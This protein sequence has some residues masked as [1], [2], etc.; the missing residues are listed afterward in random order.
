MRR[1][2]RKPD[3]P[4]VETLVE[5]CGMEKKSDTELLQLLIKCFYEDNK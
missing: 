3:Y 5:T 2:I 4:I 1:V